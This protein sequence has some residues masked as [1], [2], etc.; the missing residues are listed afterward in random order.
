MKTIRSTITVGFEEKNDALVTVS[1]NQPGQGITV[2]L[3]SPVLRQYGEHL[4]A[5][6]VNTVKE[7][8]YTDI[9]VKVLDK[10]AWDYALQAR[11][12]AALN[13]GAEE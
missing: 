5:L 12:V 10:G 9:H 11:I 4:E 1:P 7:A 8:G 3:T 2:A 13:R 6:I